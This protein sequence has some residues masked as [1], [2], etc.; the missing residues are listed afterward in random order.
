MYDGKR[1]LTILY[2]II[3]NLYDVH[4]IEKCVNIN[5]GSSFNGKYVTKDKTL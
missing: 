1:H 5:S 3:V 2:G 4:D